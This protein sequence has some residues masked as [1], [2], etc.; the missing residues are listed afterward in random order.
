MVLNVLVICDLGSAS[1]HW[2]C[3]SRRT[4]VA[5]GIWKPAL[6]GVVS[7]SHVRHGTSSLHRH[8]HG[9]LPWDLCESITCG[10]V[11]LRDVL[12]PGLLVLKHVRPHGKARTR[13]WRR[14]NMRGASMRYTRSMPAVVHVWIVYTLVA[15]GLVE[16]CLLAHLFTCEAW[17]FGRHR[18]S[19]RHGIVVAATRNLVRLKLRL[20]HW[21]LLRLRELPIRLG[22]ERLDGPHRLRCL[23][24]S[25]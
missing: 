5:Q 20:C 3:V 16:K 15:S 1:S 10:N 11:T 13:H 17:S 24:G 23:V 6:E 2:S 18:L 25:T 12:E 21:W 9:D 14:W 7:N 8:V 19:C 22:H 4:M